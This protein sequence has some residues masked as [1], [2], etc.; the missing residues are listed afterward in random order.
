MNIIKIRL[1]IQLGYH[2]IVDRDIFFFLFFSILELENFSS[3]YII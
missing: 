3:S 2:E 1:L